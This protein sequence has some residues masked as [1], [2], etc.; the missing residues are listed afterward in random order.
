MIPRYTLPRMAAIWELEHRFQVWLRIEVLACAAWAQLGKIP[1][2]ALQEI[3]GRAAFDIGLIEEL[4][5]TVRHEVVAFLT[6]VAERVGGPS[7]YIHLGM[8]SS[9]VMDTALAFQ[10]QEAASILLED[11][12]ALLGHV[13]QHDV[14]ALR[15]EESRG[16]L[17]G[18]PGCA[19]D[20]CHFAV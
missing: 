6:T 14:S 3:R 15:C 13:G 16:R 20:E 19:A 10:L 11:L 9:D 1:P 8:T 7:R 17:A 12:D 2:Q 4:E 5:E 18:A